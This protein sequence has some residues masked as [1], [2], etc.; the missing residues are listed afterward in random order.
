VVQGVK[1]DPTAAPFIKMISMRRTGKST[2]T[3]ADLGR[4]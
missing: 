3:Q 4:A 1:Q 2:A